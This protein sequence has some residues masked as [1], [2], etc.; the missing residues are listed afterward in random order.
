LKKLQIE[1][2][3]TLAVP[4]TWQFAGEV[5]ATALPVEFVTMTTQ[6]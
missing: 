4:E 1:R 2:F 6:L 3:V 5:I